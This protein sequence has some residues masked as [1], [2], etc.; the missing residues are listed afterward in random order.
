MTVEWSHRSGTERTGKC[1]EPVPQ[2]ARND[3]V[4]TRPWNVGDGTSN[5]IATTFLFR[6]SPRKERVLA[7]GPREMP[8]FLEGVGRGAEECRRHS[9]DRGRDGKNVEDT[10][11]HQKPSGSARQSKEWKGA[12]WKS[13]CRKAQGEDEVGRVGSDKKGK[14]GIPTN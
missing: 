2:K 3:Q 8:I 12:L 1:R 7:R 10:Q 4:G 6:G 13:A 5:G 9:E 14:F 11:K